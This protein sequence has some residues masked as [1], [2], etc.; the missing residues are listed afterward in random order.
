MRLTNSEA[1]R[2]AKERR[3]F[4]DRQAR[5]ELAA[6]RE[7]DKLTQLQGEVARLKLERDHALLALRNVLV[8]TNFI[9]LAAA[10]SYIREVLDER[11]EPT[12][13]AAED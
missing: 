8:E 11:I 7:P 5:E 10:R 6:I 4:K 2:I 1:I 12:P 9:S 13:D 3:D